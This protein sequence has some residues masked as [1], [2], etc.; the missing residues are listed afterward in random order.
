MFPTEFCESV[1]LKI[2]SLENGT[3]IPN[4]HLLV[5]KSLTKL[6]SPQLAHPCDFT[7]KIQL[8]VLL[9]PEK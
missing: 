6:N 9:P 5:E 8:S 1:F 2:A 4:T 3:K 7:I